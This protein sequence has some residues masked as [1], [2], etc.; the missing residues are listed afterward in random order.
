MGRGHV[1]L[2]VDLFVVVVQRA[3]HGQDLAGVVL[4]GHD[5]G[6]A[7]VLVLFDERGHLVPGHLF[8][9]LLQVHVQRGVNLQTLAPDEI[10]VLSRVELALDLVEYVEGEVGRSQNVEAFGHRLAQRQFLGEGRIGLGLADDARLRHGLECDALAALGV[11]RVV[12]GVER[13]ELGDGGEH[14]GFGQIQLRAA[15]AEVDLAGRF[16]A[17]G[18]VAVEVVVEIPL[19]HF[20]FGIAP[21]DLDGQDDLLDLA[22]IALLGALLGRDDH[23]FDELLG[24]GRATLH[25]TALEIGRK[26]TQQTA[27][28]DAGVF[29]EIAVLQRHG[30]LP[31]PGRH[32]RQR[33]EGSVAAEGPRVHAFVEQVIA[34]AVVDTHGFKLILL[35]LNDA[36]VRQLGRI[37][38]VDAQTQRHAGAG[39][40]DGQ[41]RDRGH[42][43][44]ENLAQAQ[45][46]TRTVVVGA[47][48][49][50]ARHDDAIV[51][52]KSA[53]SSVQHK[54]RH[55][56]PACRQKKLKTQNAPRAFRVC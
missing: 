47:L 43:D 32:L 33:H 54:C 56:N 46:R 30:R 18:Q 44:Q 51:T 10:G 9:V 16:N 40:A 42:R 4:D 55:R 19:Q 15:L 35:R 28:V 36:G 6:V 24:D 38:V 26:R 11:F 41:Q 45:P 3:D 39:D 49:F 25:R 34:R 7:G 50:A 37:G 29:E 27:H 12:D 22:R 52:F 20:F 13:R 5:A 14:G 1:D 53:H 48:P 2:A 31:H 21:G 23:V 8:G 17:V